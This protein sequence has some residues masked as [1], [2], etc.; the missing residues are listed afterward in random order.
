MNLTFIP[1]L[2]SRNASLQTKLLS[3]FLKNGASSYRSGLCRQNTLA[4]LSP[5]AVT[6][7]DAS[8]R[9]ADKTGQV[10]RGEFQESEQQ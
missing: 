6:A 5:D 1:T 3:F 9:G 2:R 10:F 8:L 7:S 4:R